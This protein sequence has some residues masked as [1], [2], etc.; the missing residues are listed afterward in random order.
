MLLPLLLPVIA[1][2]NARAPSPWKSLVPSDAGLEA[3]RTLAG[4]ELALEL[5]PD[6]LCSITRAKDSINCSSTACVGCAF[7]ILTPPCSDSLPAAAIPPPLSPKICPPPAPAGVI[8]GSTM[9]QLS[10]P[11]MQGRF[12]RG[13]QCGKTSKDPVMRGERLWLISDAWPPAEGHPCFLPLL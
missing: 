3:A 12:Q 11:Q 10:T 7:S 13:D 9:P 4:L 6:L 1:T 8:S 2:A 5:A